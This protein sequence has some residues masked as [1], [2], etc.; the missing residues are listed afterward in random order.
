M[1]REKQT[2]DVYALKTLRK[3][4]ARKR[5][6][7]STEDERDVLAN[8]NSPWIPRLQYAFQVIQQLNPNIKND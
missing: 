6:V 7:A 8:A 4:E 1:V 5:A 3:E 2:C